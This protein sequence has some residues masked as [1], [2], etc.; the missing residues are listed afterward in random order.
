M[1]GKMAGWLDWGR[2]G[3]SEGCP[4][5]LILLLPQGSTQAAQGSAGNVAEAMAGVTLSEVHKVSLLL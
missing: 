2:L 1:R 5:L 3:I 4:L